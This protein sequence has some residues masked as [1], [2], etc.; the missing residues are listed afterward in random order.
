[1]WSTVA[2]AVEGNRRYLWGS[3]KAKKGQS[4]KRDVSGFRGCG[5]GRRER[6]QNIA[7]GGGGVSPQ[8]D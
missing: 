7:R 1:M 4:I 2:L 3:V 6:K 5:L 8:G